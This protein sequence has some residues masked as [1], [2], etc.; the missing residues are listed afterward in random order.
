VDGRARWPGRAGTRSALLL[1][2]W[3]GHDRVGTASRR[4]GQSGRDGPLGD[5]GAA[6]S[7]VPI[8]QID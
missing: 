5:E 7:G 2:A 4:T 6:S 8:F 3:S 1:D